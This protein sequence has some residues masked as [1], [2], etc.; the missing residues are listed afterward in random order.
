MGIFSSD[1]PAEQVYIKG[2]I[3]K[4]DICSHDKFKHQEAQLNTKIATLLNLDWTNKTAN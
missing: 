3:L 1:K 4:C 2:K